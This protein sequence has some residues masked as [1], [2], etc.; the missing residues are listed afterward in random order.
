MSTDHIRRSD[1]VPLNSNIEV[2]PTGL[3]GPRDVAIAGGKVYWVDS[4]QDWIK[5]ADPNG[6][7]EE[8]LVTGLT[9]PQ[10]IAVDL[11]GGKVYWSDNGTG[12]DRIR[13]AN[14]TGGPN[15]MVED[16]VTG[17]T[18]P[19]AIALDLVNRKS[20]LSTTVRPT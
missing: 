12:E 11:A 3:D 9:L 7:N 13:R 14:I 20:I 5:R 18:S 2:G 1:L 4:N 16:V 6:A 17:L 10:G 8:T 15:N 19:E